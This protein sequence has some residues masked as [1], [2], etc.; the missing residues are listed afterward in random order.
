MASQVCQNLLHRERLLCLSPSIRH[1]FHP[2]G[3]E[4]NPIAEERD[5]LTRNQCRRDKGKKGAEEKERALHGEATGN[6]EEN[7]APPAF[8]SLRTRSLST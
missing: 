3:R 2:C 4:V 6:G 7:S 1:P 5:S 8:P